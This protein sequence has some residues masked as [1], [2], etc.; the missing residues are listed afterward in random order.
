M[1]EEQWGAATCT[2]ECHMSWAGCRASCRLGETPRGC[3][4]Y[5]GW[6]V[7]VVCW[8]GGGI[9]VGCMFGLVVGLACWVAT[10]CL[11]FAQSCASQ[12]QVSG[13]SRAGNCVC[14]VVCS[15]ERCCM[16]AQL[17]VEYGLALLPGGCFGMVGSGATSVG[18]CRSMVG[19][20][21]YGSVSSIVGGQVAVEKLR[22]CCEVPC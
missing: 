16:F 19:C 14:R 1:V 17:R 9:D 10:L 3:K 11:V 8:C 5:L 18:V 15:V 21:G 7:Q 13:L 20:W 12:V 22:G 2:P 6:S 4:V